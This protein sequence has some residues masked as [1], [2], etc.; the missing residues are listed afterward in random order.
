MSAT[1]KTERRE[2]G[3]YTSSQPKRPIGPDLWWLPDGPVARWFC[4]R[5]C[6]STC[7]GRSAW[8]RQARMHRAY[9]RRT[10]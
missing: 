8:R 1:P 3:R 5:Q 9:G 2:R 10:R 7:H 6:A 4:R